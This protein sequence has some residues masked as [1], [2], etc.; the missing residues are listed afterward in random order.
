MDESIETWVTD[1]Q[2]KY[3]RIP[4][5][6]PHAPMARVVDIMKLQGLNVSSSDLTVNFTIEDS[7][8]E[9]N[10]G[11]FTFESIGGKLI[12]RKEESKNECIMNIL[13]LSSLVYCGTDPEDLSA[14]GWISNL[15]EEISKNLKE[16]FSPVFPFLVENF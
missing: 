3:V 7:W 15:T 5:H 8:C 9:W 16:M 2:A 1:S 6:T 14:R 13:A 11:S 10:T 4:L 12:V